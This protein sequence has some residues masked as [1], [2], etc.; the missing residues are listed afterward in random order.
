MSGF[1]G[2]RRFVPARDILDALRFF[3]R[4]PAGERGAGAPLGINRYAWAAPVA[5]VAVGLAGALALALTGLFGL[6]P[7]IRAALATAALVAVTGALHEDG[8]AD[9]ADGFGGGATRAAKLE[10]MRDSRIGAYGAVALTLAL[11]LRVGALTAALDGGFWRAAL[12]LIAVAALSR[13]GALT[14]LALL[15]PARAD[16]AGASAGR[17]EPGA[18]L[19]AWGSALAVAIVLGLA[20]LGLDARSRRD[21]RQRRGRMGGRRARSPR[22]RWPDR[23]R[24]RR[25]AAVSRDRRMVRPSHQAFGRLSDRA[26]VR[27]RSVDPLRQGLRRR[28]ALR[29]LH[30]LRPHGRGNWRLDNDD[31]ERAPRRHGRPSGAADPGALARRPR[32]T[33]RPDR[34]MRFIV[35]ALVLA[36]ALAALVMTPAHSTLLG[37]DHRRFASAAVGTAVLVWLAV[38]GLRSTRPGDVARM[39][40]AAAVWAA[41]IVALTGVYAYRYEASDI[42]GRIAGELFPSEPEVGSGGEVI[43]NQRLGGEFAITGRVNGARVTFLFDTGASAVVLT[44]AD[45]RRAGINTAGLEYDVPVSTANGAA[46][47]AEMRLSEVAVGP[48]VMHNVAALVARPGALDESLLGMSFLGRLKGYAVERG[49]LVLTA[50]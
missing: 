24:R 40:G 15:A 27:A 23:R 28:S 17:L 31:R 3:T 38:S 1:D 14:P 11:I 49:R 2:P 37:L 25:G 13:A 22:D 50:R 35:P 20:C 41:L 43:V 33:D 19:A 39:V 44:A 48:I 30:R 42:V 6:P 36:A 47:A 4:M 8:L 16:G 18:H 7:L 9:V 29:A 26:Y 12:S 46:L 34:M 45:A 10:I 32:R 5:G 21:T